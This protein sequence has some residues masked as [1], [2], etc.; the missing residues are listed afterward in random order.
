ML[1][2]GVRLRVNL[3]EVPDARWRLEHANQLCDYAR[4]RAPRQVPL[5]VRFRLPVL[6]E[7]IGASIV[8]IDV[9]RDAPTSF[10]RTGIGKQLWQSRFK[11]VYHLSPGFAFEQHHDRH[12]APPIVD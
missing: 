9:R 1:G 4:F 12:K 5:V 2:G 6:D 7:Y 11:S 8:T 10:V 3:V